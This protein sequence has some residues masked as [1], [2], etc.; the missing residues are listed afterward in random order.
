MTSPAQISCILPL[1]AYGLN[2]GRNLAHSQETPGIPLYLHFP[3][4][5]EACHRIIHSRNR[6][7]SDSLS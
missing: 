5:L 6:G 7:L 1:L 2:I 3:G 4:A